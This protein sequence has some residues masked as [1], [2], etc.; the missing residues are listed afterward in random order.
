MEAEAWAQV[1]EKETELR[2]RAG[3][4]YGGVIAGADAAQA[5]AGKGG[6]ALAALR[7]ARGALETLARGR[8]EEAGPSPAGSGAQD[9]SGADLLFRLGLEASLVVDTPE[10]VW[11]FL[12]EGC[13]TAAVGRLQQAEAAWAA[14][15]SGRYPADLLRFF[16]VIQRHW[17]K[18]QAMRGQ[19]MQV[20]LQ[21]L[22]SGAALSD[23]DAAGLLASLARLG[24][25]SSPELLQLFLEKR[26]EGA[27]ACLEDIGDMAN[28]GEGG[29][30]G[31]QF[32][33]AQLI[34]AGRLLQ[35]TAC[36][37]FNLFAVAAADNLGRATETPA[38]VALAPSFTDGSRGGSDTED[39]D[40]PEAGLVALPT[41]DIAALCGEWLADLQDTFKGCDT[42]AGIV[43]AVELGRT[44]SEIK[45]ALAA[46]YDE[47]SVSGLHTL[48]TAEPSVARACPVLATRDLGVWGI[49][50]DG[51]LIGRG[52]ALIAATFDVVMEEVR[53]LVEAG[54]ASASRCS[55]EVPGGSDLAS[56]VERFDMHA[57]PSP[58][59][60]LHM[61]DSGEVGSG[62]H[63]SAAWRSLLRGVQAALE[64]GLSRALQDSLHILLSPDDKTAL[65][66]RIAALEP[67]V[68]AKCDAA[69]RQ[70]L[71]QARALL[72][73][74]EKGQASMS[75]ASL[76][77]G[78]LA[79][80]LQPSSGRALRAAF[81]PPREWVDLEQGL[82]Q[83]AARSEALS[84][85]PSE[86]LPGLARDLREFA[87][88]SYRVWV[89]WNVGHLREAL[90]ASLPEVQKAL[91]PSGLP[92]GWQKVNA[93]EGMN[94]SL[95][96][97][98][99]P[100]ILTLLFAACEEVQRAN[101]HLLEPAAVHELREEV[102]QAASAA[103]EA[104]ADHA[105]RKAIP[106][107]LCL[108]LIFD[109]QFSGGLL[110]LS[111]EGPSQ[112][113]TAASADVARAKRAFSSR[114][115]PIDWATYEPHLER[116][117]ASCLQKNNV[118]LGSL[119]PS[120][121]SLRRLSAPEKFQ[122]SASASIIAFAPNPGRFGY[123]PI[124]TPDKFSRRLQRKKVTQAAHGGDRSGTGRPK[125]QD[126]GGAV[127]A[128]LGAVL[129]DRA[130]EMQAFAQDLATNSP[131]GS[132]FS[133]L[134]GQNAGDAR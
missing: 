39:R 60:G 44:E 108:Q 10:V 65:Q 41:E 51:P 101:G 103:Y 106:E 83:L 25:M 79:S 54:C 93:G 99:S 3:A 98:P 85:T 45:A 15:D 13:F 7:A 87:R 95:P 125:S 74:L 53:P 111:K 123:L 9:D 61:W 94:F 46:P 88:E 21:R 114:L 120:Q 97:A 122:A 40:G 31:L 82:P 119:L 112:P 71:H 18:V 38:L 132:M 43:S 124:A 27:R 6:E 68:A 14:V 110:L 129:G 109:L 16:P 84:T 90:D 76:Y 113:S 77:L 33:V 32:L 75:D 34:R 19:V 116:L 28:Q 50:F 12:D 102:L 121:H 92:G 26:L 57:A 11:S 66:A 59:G 67:V 117:V 70:I 127:G 69:I 36:Q 24:G 115:D 29:G 91:S 48:F 105:G 5:M 37:A 72:R 64:R 22:G 52:E 20:V 80:I 86:L 73:G 58:G 134:T 104:F 4:G 35:A 1:S 56:W 89:S 118:L 17:P 2:A 42:F 78:E 133:S 47:I 62:R 55:A 81:G 100:S 23:E 131:F 128:G 107:A 126:L 96:A 8:G 130:A 30:E 63:V 49:C